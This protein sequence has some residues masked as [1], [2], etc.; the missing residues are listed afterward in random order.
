MTATHKKN[1]LR[2]LSSFGFLLDILPFKL[3]DRIPAESFTQSISAAFDLL[4]FTGT[5]KN[6]IAYLPLW[7]F[8]YNPSNVMDEVKNALFKKTL[9]SSTTPILRQFADGIAH[10]CIRTKNSLVSYCDYLKN[11]KLPLFQ[12][13]FS[14]DP[15]AE[16]LKTFEDSF[17]RLGSSH[18][19]MVTVEGGGHEDFLLSSELHGSFYHELLELLR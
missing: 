10:S 11:I 16:P 9:D 14:L 5:K 4:P 18:K 17:S 1:M 15:L 3:L 6:A 8:L 19:T 7:S 12:V 2:T 13:A